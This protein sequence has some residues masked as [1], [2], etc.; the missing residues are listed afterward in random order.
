M[1]PC[2]CTEHEYRP[3]AITTKAAGAYIKD[4]LILY[5][6]TLINI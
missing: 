1:K 2:V 3:T 5:N 6:T 4:E